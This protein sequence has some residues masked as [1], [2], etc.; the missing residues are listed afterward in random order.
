MELVKHE[1]C[2]QY[3]TRRL[4]EG[5]GIISQSGF[6][7]I[8]QS[9]EGIIRPVDL[10]N[11]VETLRPN[12]AGAECALPGQSGCAVCP[13]HWACVDE[14]IPDEMGTRLDSIDLNDVYQRDLFNLPPSSGSGTINH[15]IV[16]AR[17]YTTSA[18]TQ[19]SIKICIR[20]DATVT[21]DIARTITTSWV[22]YSRQWNANP[23]GGAWDWADID[24]LQIGIS[25]RNAA[26]W[27]KSYCTQVYVE[28]D[29]TP[30]GLG[31]KSALMG[32]KMIGEGLI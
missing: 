22:N 29:F 7:V 25:M 12:A 11:D 9:P 32:G 13:G 3:V 10:R 23:V 8:L 1:T 20:S 6:N 27:V 31:D 17:C 15:I 26:D 18:P 30:P 28:I 19:A 24:A 14:A 21:E 4:S 16:V 5:W 2:Q